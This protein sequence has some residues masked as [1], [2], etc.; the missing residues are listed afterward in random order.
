MTARGPFHS[1]LAAPEMPVERAALIVALDV[2]P[3]L[4]VEHYLE[5]FDRL[6]EPLAAR[7]AR[8][9]TLHARASILGTYMYDELGFRGD[10]E[11]YYDPRN[12][13][14]HEVFDRRRGIP[15]TLA[16][17]LIALGRRAG[18]E[19]EGVGFPGHF[20]VRLGGPDGLVLD[21]FFRARL[22]TSDALERIVR[23]TLGDAAPMLPE[24]LGGVTTHAIVARILTNL[25][26]IYESQHEHSRALLVCD[27]LVDL[28]G[29]PEARRDRGLHALALG[30][31]AVGRDDLEAYLAARPD[32]A[33]HERIRATLSGVRPS[34]PAN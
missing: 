32:A 33:D 9:K 17:V 8:A 4:N 6:A 19:L 10:E 3:G 28:T 27:R 14:L 31:R 22:L 12:C 16:V 5:C 13:Y 34:A 29:Q 30:A 24:H 11:N 20:V 7:I 2:D 26:A 21:P 18:L 25:K 1:I 15:V 23:R